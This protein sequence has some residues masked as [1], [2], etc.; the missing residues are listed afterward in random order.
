MNEINFGKIIEKGKTLIL[1]YDQGLEHGPTDFNDKNVDPEYIIEIANRGKFNGIVLQKGIAEKYYDG[2]VPL[3]LKLN[4]KTNLLEGEPIAK[5]LCTVKEAIELGAKAVGYT[6]YVGSIHEP[7]MFE[8]FENIER[9]A[10]ENGLPLI[11]WM[12]PR[13]KAIKNELDSNTL[14][15]AARIG[16]ELGA[17]MIKMKYNHN[18][19]SLRW[20]IESAGKT[21]VVIAGGLK[22]D[23]EQILSDIKE[24]M[25]AGATGLAIGRNI[26]QHENPL[27]MAKAV[28]EMIF[29]NISVEKAL[30]ILR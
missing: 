22:E 9:E 16:L 19:D 30:K 24:V 14:A 27:K 12:Y 21:R 18:P 7:E 23:E 6:I 3:I 4:G 17:D 13:G 25:S 29:G 20:I 5:Q 28:R 8:E 1:A 10:H 2:K 11:A 15:Y 26:W